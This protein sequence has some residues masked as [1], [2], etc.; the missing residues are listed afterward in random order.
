ME[1]AY[2]SEVSAQTNYG[3]LHFRRL[4]LNNTAKKSGCD[5]MY[6]VEVYPYDGGSTFLQNVGGLLPAYKA[7]LPT[8]S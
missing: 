3:V 6:V 7:S 8:S 2:L 5:R 4:V 1:E